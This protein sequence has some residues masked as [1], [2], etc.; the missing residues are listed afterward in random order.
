MSTYRRGRNGNSGSYEVG[1]GKP[2]AETRFKPGES[3]NKKGRPKSSTNFG[4]LLSK[5][6]DRKLT[7][8]QDGKRRNITTREAMIMNLISKA[9]KGD[10]KAISCVLN[11][12]KSHEVDV[13]RVKTHEEWVRE[14]E[15]DDLEHATSKK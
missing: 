7:I 10:T 11:L 1:Y 3:G 15:L 8:V 5:N 2:P 14:M 9:T 4:D 13:Y 6:L 12:S